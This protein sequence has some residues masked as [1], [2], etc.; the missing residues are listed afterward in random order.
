MN[1]DQPYAQ[2]YHTVRV[3][4]G[5]REKEKERKTDRERG[6]DRRLER[7]LYNCKQSR[8]RC[9]PT[10]KPIWIVTEITV[11]DI[12]FN[13]LKGEHIIYTCMQ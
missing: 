8:V 3:W 12:I 5:E 6:R 2:T 4:R 10:H 13:A 11:I 1:V 9:V 7:R